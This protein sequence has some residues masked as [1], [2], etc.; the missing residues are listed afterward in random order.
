MLILKVSAIECEVV[1]CIPNGAELVIFMT[2]EA[3]AFDSIISGGPFVKH[4]PQELSLRFFSP[5]L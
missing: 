5:G 2:C 3:G 4:C 1:S